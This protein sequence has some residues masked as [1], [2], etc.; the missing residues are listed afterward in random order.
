M[1]QE[2]N[3]QATRY[4]D[5]RVVEEEQPAQPQA[6]A[7]SR[8][9]SR[10]WPAAQRWLALVATV[11]ALAGLMLPWYTVP[12]Q[13]AALSPLAMA[14]ALLAGLDLASLPPDAPAMQAAQHAL[15]AMPSAA[16]ETAARAALLWLAFGPL[17][18]A[19]LVLLV[20]VPMWRGRIAAARW[21]G[22]G[23]LWLVAAWGVAW[24]LGLRQGVW[25]DLFRMAG[26][27]FWCTLASLC[28]LELARRFS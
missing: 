7:P 21:F 15:S 4:E 24:L 26:A 19:A 20:A 22:M 23:L 16:E 11:A 17:W 27:G 1:P 12:G 10:L 8:R 25:L 9:L 13:G 3:R 28:T 6:Q 2:T 5:L 18:L 14:H